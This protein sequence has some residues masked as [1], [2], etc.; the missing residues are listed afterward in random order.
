MSLKYHSVQIS[1]IQKETIPRP[2]VGT[3][4]RSVC[5]SVICF[6]SCS[7]LSDMYAT[8]PANCA[9]GERREKC[10]NASHVPPDIMTLGVHLFRVGPSAYVD[11]SPAV[12]HS[13][14]RG[15]TKG[16]IV[17]HSDIQWHTVKN[18]GKHGDTKWHMVTQSD[19]WWHTVRNTVTHSNT[20][21]HINSLDLVWV[22]LLH[23]HDRQSPE[24]Q[25]SAKPI[26]EEWAYFET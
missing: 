13:A 15:D 21:W 8:D 19:T 2:L 7:W 14:T 17:T 25:K 3:F 9:A 12:T 23:Q 11:C 20:Q 26:R 1:Y 10:L 24:P 22:G 16:H 5:K 4:L 6:E 18:S